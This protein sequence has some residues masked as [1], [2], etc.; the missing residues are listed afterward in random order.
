MALL[1]A[2]HPRG[3]AGL[4]AIF[5]P[6]WHE[7]CACFHSLHVKLTKF[8]QVKVLPID[9]ETFELRGTVLLEALAGG[10]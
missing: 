2:T 7:I 4:S 5:L 6:I 9:I 1:L 3:T 10:L 8:V